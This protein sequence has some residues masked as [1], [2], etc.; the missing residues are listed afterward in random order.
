MQLVR[1]RSSLT[2]VLVIYLQVF[3]SP[4]Q[5]YY[6]KATDCHT[7]YG[8]IG[9]P[10]W[11]G[12]QRSVTRRESPTHSTDSNSNSSGQTT[13]PNR[14]NVKNV[15]SDDTTIIVNDDDTLTGDSGATGSS[16]NNLTYCEKLSI[17]YQRRPAMLCV[18]YVDCP[19]AQRKTAESVRQL[20]CGITLVGS[21]RVCC[22]ASGRSGSIDSSSAD[23]TI[24]YEHD[25][26]ARQDGDDGVMV[27]AAAK[28]RPKTTPDGAAVA[29][30]GKHQQQQQQ[31]QHSSETVIVTDDKIETIG[32]MKGSSVN[33][34]LTP[35]GPPMETNL[36][37][38]SP[39][40]N[41][42]PREC[43]RPAGGDSENFQD[44]TRI[45]GGKSA[46]RNAWP[47]FALLMIQRR[48]SGRR[49]PE[50]GGTLITNRYVLTA[51][52][53][54][55]GQNRRPI[56]AASLTI[57]LGEFDLRQAGDGELD[58]GV[59]A[60][61]PHPSFQQKSFK[62]DIAL[63]K[64]DRT[65]ALGDTI[66][67]ACLPFDD[68]KLASQTP[69]AVDNQTAWVLGFGQTSYNGRTSDQLRQADLRIVQHAKCK[70]AFSH[71]VKLTREYVCASSQ[72]DDDDHDHDHQPEED[73]NSAPE[74]S[75]STNSKLKDSCQGDSG[76]PLMMQAPGSAKRGR[77]YIYGLVSFGYR[78][79]SAGFPGVYT[80][81]NRYLT[82]IESHLEAS[83]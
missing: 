78:C 9:K 55:V 80:R 12:G 34:T 71:L 22:S 52:H 6:K 63:I 41:R 75:K 62:N 65:V 44:E 66:G 13:A 29:H 39:R 18:D 61:W 46:R 11:H 7:I 36:D 19:E 37:D 16:Q 32:T 49:A 48:N 31:H 40:G 81:V 54:V 27:A 28:R 33:K 45:I 53:C 2:I 57:R 74:S 58:V 73:A 69:G 20:S 70:R 64:L 68:L 60:I 67:L 25:E 47:W 76:G 59:E 17:T 83:G 77:W 79:A 10:G 15:S 21:I 8:D 1:T 82:W 5:Q 51:A 14:H 3:T 56:R 30:E 43:G 4:F 50:C 35:A 23:D 38:P 26:R 24:I 72:F 42:F